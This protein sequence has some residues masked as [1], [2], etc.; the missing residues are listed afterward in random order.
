MKIP[1]IKRLEDTSFRC[2]C[3]RKSPVPMHM[4]EL[5]DLKSEVSELRSRVDQLEPYFDSRFDELE[6]YFES[7][8]DELES[9]FESQSQ[10][11]S[12]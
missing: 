12:G 8:L 2:Q 10:T 11:Y 5:E 7:R 9:D 4:G 3:G 1:R 6:F